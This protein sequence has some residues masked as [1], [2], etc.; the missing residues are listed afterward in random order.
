MG[1]SVTCNSFANQGDIRP[2]QRLLR[3]GVAAT[4]I[5]YPLVTGVTPLGWV[6]LL[7]LI[8]IYPMFSAIVGWD[9]VRFILSASDE[10][11]GVNRTVARVGL[12][13]IGTG[14]ISAT[15]L[16]DTNPLGGLVILALLAVLPILAAIFGEN[17]VA[18]L[19]ESCRHAKGE[20]QNIDQRQV[21]LKAGTVEYL[22][23]PGHRN[24]VRE[25]VPPRHEAA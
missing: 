11:L 25:A 9:P 19:V 23:N 20:L 22:L 17:P 18:A 12:T 10:M 16:V 15:M 24:T 7:P 4:M 1:T 5:L 14:L 6:A 8:A 3:A 2:G 13:V 21:T